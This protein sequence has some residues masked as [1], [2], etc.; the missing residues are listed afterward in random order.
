MSCP[1]PGHGKKRGDRNP[2]LSLTETPDGTLLVH[3]KAGCSQEAVWR[4]LCQLARVEPPRANIILPSQRTHQRNGS[5]PAPAES[6]HERLTVDA[7]A[8]AKGL[9]ALLLREWGLIECERGVAIPYLDAD[10]NQV[11]TRYRHALEGE[12]RFSWARG[13]RPCMYGLWNLPLWD[14]SE[15]VYLCEGETDA[16]TLWHAGMPALGIPGA[17]VWREAWW[18]PLKRFARICIIPDADAAGRQLLEK[19]GHTCPLELQERVRVLELPEG[20]KDANELYLQVGGDG[21]RF[22]EAIAGLLHSCTPIEECTN[23]QM[24]ESDS[25]DGIP[26]F[27]PLS[28]ILARAES[29]EV[30]YLPLLGTDGLIARGTITLLGAHPKAGKTTLMIHACREWLRLGLKV[31][32]LTEEPTAV[33]NLRLKQYPELA[34]LYL[35]EIPRAHPENWAKAILREAPDIVIVDTIRRFAQIRDENDSASVSAALSYFVDLV[36]DLPRTAIVFA[37]HTRKNLSP[38]GEVGD[39]AGSHAFTAEVDAILLL[40]PVREHSRQR[41]LTPVASRLWAFTPDALVLE[42]AEDGSTYAVKG[43]AS[44]VLSEQKRADA[45]AKV[46]EALQALGEATVDELTECL[47]GYSRRTVYDALQEL[48]AERQVEREGTGKKG[49][50]YRF[51]AFVHSCNSP[52]ECTNAQMHE[53]P[54]GTDGQPAPPLMPD[55]FQNRTPLVWDAID[56]FLARQS[57][58]EDSFALTPEEADAVRVMLAFAEARGFPPLTVDGYAIQGDMAGW[59]TAA[60]QLAGTP[61][62]ARATALLHRLDAAGSPAAPAHH[63]TLRNGDGGRTPAQL[64]LEEG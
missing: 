22:R 46:L 12:N 49:N 3:C 59:L 13:N 63:T 20:V 19:L 10:G 54:A 61:A 51:C 5:T 33:W 47:T 31:V 58:P 8:D 41:L 60:Q 7:Y 11:A 53:S 1:V 36:N 55:A 37:H 50:P 17:S 44:E 45:K 57:S 26:T 18:E 30:E 14:D 6:S 4:T 23:A 29:R 42:L 52:I 32:Y 27:A 2:S 24:H 62:V 21:E 40:A 43:V 35:N 56:D 34:S 9:N 64:T 38:E 25:W 15:T 48:Y 39:I 28:E 16:L